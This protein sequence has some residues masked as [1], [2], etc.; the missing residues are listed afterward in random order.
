MYSPDAYHRALVFAAGKH[1]EQKFPGSDLP[2]LVHVV[3]VASEVIA[4]LPRLALDDPDLGVVCA[5]LHDTI[6]DT[7]NTEA[8]KQALATEAKER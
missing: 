1:R 4:H 2:Y 7:A 6:E 3:T 5:L 8:D